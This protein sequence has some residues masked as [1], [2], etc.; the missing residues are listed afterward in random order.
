MREGED[1]P[2]FGPSHLVPFS[3]DHPP[4]LPNPTGEWGPRGDWESSGDGCGF[5]LLPQSSRVGLCEGVKVGLAGRG[6]A[7]A[8]SPHL[9]LVSPRDWRAVLAPER[10]GSLCST[11]LSL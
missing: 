4:L 5:Q 9:I 8:L 2:V 1:H 3:R 11:A 7:A 6:A 10:Q